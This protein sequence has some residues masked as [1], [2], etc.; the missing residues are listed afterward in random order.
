MLDFKKNDSPN[1][2][3]YRPIILFSHTSKTFEEILFNQI[4]HYIEPYFSDFL[5]SLWISQSTQQHLLK[6][7][8]K[9]KHLL[10]NVYNIGVFFMDLLKAFNVL[11]HSLLLAKSD[12]YGFSLKSTI[13]IQRYLNKSMQKVIVNNNF[14]LWKDIYGVS[15]GSMPG[16]F[17]SNNFL[18]YISS[19]ST[20]CDMCNCADDNALYAYSR[21]FHQ[22]QEYLKKALEIS[23]N[24]TCDNYMVLNFRKSEFMNFGKI[25]ETEVFTYHEIRLKKILLRNYLVLQ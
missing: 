25:N 18:I 15:Q 11:N 17:L 16:R 10:D 3:N 8:E 19:F 5:K 23:V 9:L 2:E 12:A 22:V 14:S 4:N 13:F 6:M 20:T 21:D 7:S 24:W 1:K